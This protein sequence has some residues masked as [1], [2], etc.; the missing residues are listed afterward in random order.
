MENYPLVR[1]RAG[2]S[3]KSSTLTSNNSMAG[4]DQMYQNVN[5]YRIGI[6]GKKWWWSLFSWLVDVSIQNAWIL[7]RKMGSGHDHLDFRQKVAMSYLS[8][9]QTAP[10]KSGRK[11]ISSRPGFNDARYYRTDHFPVPS[12]RRRCHGDECSSTVRMACSKCNVGLCLKCFQSYH[13]Q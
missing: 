7:D 2:Q 4:T 10:K 12:N 9:F 1:L 11:R 5:C 13:T 8:R 6:R 3:K